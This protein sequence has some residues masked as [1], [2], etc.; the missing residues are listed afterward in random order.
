MKHYLRSCKSIEPRYNLHSYISA[1]TPT[2]EHGIFPSNGQTALSKHDLSRIDDISLIHRVTMANPNTLTRMI[3]KKSIWNKFTTS[4]GN[5]S[6]PRGY[7]V[8]YQRRSDGRS[9]EMRLARTGVARYYQLGIYASRGQW[10]SKRASLSL[11]HTLGPGRPVFTLPYNTCSVR[12]Q[13][14]YRSLLGGTKC[15]SSY[16]YIIYARILSELPPRV[17][18]CFCEFSAFLDFRG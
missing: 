14:G 12:L 11:T 7:T 10:A 4:R 8:V 5:S 17:H 1:H 3:K 6:A 18:A 9:R 2:V 13:C 16:N 15:L